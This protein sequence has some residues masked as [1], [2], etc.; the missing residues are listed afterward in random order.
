MIKFKFTKFSADGTIEYFLAA[1]K[2]D[3]NLGYI[4]YKENGPAVIE[5]DGTQI[6]YVNGHKGNPNGPTIIKPNGYM[7]YWTNNKLGRKEEIGPAII[8]P[9]G[10]K[11]WVWNNLLHRE[12]GPAREFADGSTQYYYEGKYIEAK[13]DK[14]YFRKLKYSNFYF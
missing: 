1:G 11:D 8:Y 6:Y 14:E 2:S 3:Q 7:E 10:G 5:A 13:N 9:D 4:P 12:Y